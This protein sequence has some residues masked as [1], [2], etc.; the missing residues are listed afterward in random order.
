MND[1]K[2][3]REQQYQACKGKDDSLGIMVSSEQH[4]RHHDGNWNCD[5][6]DDA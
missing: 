1:E 6:W 5:K 3:E 4:E 2:N